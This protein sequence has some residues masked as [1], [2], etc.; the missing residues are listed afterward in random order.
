[1]QK[2]LYVCLA[3]CLLQTVHSACADGT[4]ATVG[5]P[6][7]TKGDCTVCFPLCATCNAAATCLTYIDRVKGVDRTA[8]TAYC[9]GASTTG[10]AVGYNKNNDSCDRCMDGCLQCSIDYDICIKCKSGWDFDRAGLQCIRATLG[11]AAVV[12]AL[13]VLT[14]LIVVITCICACKL[15]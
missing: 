7:A 5:G 13:S 2:I 10:A 8:N 6:D 4:Y 11:L 12:L 3:L 15:G 9:A 1:M 14:L